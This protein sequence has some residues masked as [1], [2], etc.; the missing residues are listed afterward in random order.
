MT[1][2]LNLDKKIHTGADTEGAQIHFPLFNYEPI[3]KKNSLCWRG[4]VGIGWGP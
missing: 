3:L 4:G 1:N 2:K